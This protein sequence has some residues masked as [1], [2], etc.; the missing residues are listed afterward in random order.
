MNIL[1][2]WCEHFL[3]WTIET[4]DRFYKVLVRVKHFNGRELIFYN[5]MKY[6]ESSLHATR[7]I[8]CEVF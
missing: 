1:V 3:H 4:F 8:Y 6:L 7:S 5:D 2:C